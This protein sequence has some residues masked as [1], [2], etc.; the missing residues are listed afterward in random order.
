ML[1][2][3]PNFDE[4]KFTNVVTGDESWVQYFEPVRKVSNKIW[5]TNSKRPVI[6]KC[7]FSAKTVLYAIFFSGERVVIQV[8]VKKDNS[9][10]GKYWKAVVL[11]KLK[12]YYLRY[13]AQSWVSNMSDFNMIMHQPI[14][15]PLLHF[16]LFYLFIYLFIYL[17]FFFLQKEKVTVLLHSPYSRKVFFFFTWPCPL[18]FLPF[19]PELISGYASP[20]SR[21]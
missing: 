21:C 19:F 11:K 15:L 2:T 13:D 14:R 12:Q 20:L 3:L 7:K 5:A 1:K 10:T 6:A 16:I 4:K 9:V 17:F 8:P 18:C